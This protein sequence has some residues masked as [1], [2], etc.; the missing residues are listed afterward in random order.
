MC[1]SCWAFSAV[2]FMK[3]VYTR[4]TGK[5]ESLSEQELVD[6][7]NEGEMSHGFIEAIENH[8]DKIDLEAIYAYT[9]QSKGKC[10]ADDS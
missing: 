8:G 3:S 5:L 2:E 6:C 1:C 9:A 7:T 4:V 10:L